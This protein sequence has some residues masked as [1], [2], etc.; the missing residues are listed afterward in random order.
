M[1]LSIILVFVSIELN[2]A[3]TMIQSVGV[4]IVDIDRMTKVIHR[5]GDKFLKKILT[6]IEYNY[7]T[8]KAGQSASVAA[9]FAVKEALYKALPENIQRS[10]GWLDIEIINDKSGRPHINCLGNI[11]NLKDTLK[12]HVSISHSKSSAIAMVVL[13]KR[14]A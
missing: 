7:C 13:E 14:S 2:R 10:A 6:P 8:D 1:P 12:I 4:D 3:N 5:W 9:R 11:R